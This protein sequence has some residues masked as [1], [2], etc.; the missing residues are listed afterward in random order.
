MIH[1]RTGEDC[2][3]IAARLATAIRLPGYRI[4]F[5]TREFKKIRQKLFWEEPRIA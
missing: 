4:L 3:A 5:S 1:G 2:Q